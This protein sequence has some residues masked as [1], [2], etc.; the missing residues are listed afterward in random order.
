MLKPYIDL[1]VVTASI[2]IFI[3]FLVIFI[4]GELQKKVWKITLNP[5]TIV[6]VNFAGL[7]KTFQHLYHEFDG[8]ITSILPNEYNEYEFLF[9]RKAGKRTLVISEFYHRNYDEMKS[10]IEKKC[11][12]LGEEKFNLGRELKFSLL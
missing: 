6:A 10:I 8:Y 11:I 5:D 3:F 9:L 7:G 12:F 4:R 2:P 1:R